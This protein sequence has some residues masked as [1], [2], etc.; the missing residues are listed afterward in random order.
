[1]TKGIELR[2]YQQA[3]VEAMIK[4]RRGMCVAPAGAGKTIIAAECVAAGIKKAYQDGNCFPSVIWIAH[5]TEQAEQGKAALERFKPDGFCTVKVCCYASNPDTRA[6]D[7]LI[8][9]EA[10][11]AGASSVQRLVDAVSDLCSVYGFTA[12]P[13]REDGVDIESIIGPIRYT[14][15]R[16]EIQ[17]VGGVLP[18]E[19]RVVPCGVKDALDD[20][21][22]ALAGNYYTSRL[23][24]CDD[25]N[26]T[27]EQWK[28]C[29]YRSALNI[30]IRENQA[31]DLLIQKICRLHDTDS[32]LI[33]VD[34]KEH[35]KR[36]K[37][38]IPESRFVSSGAAGR[39]KTIEAFKDGMI[40]VLI[41]TSLADEGLDAPIAG[42]LIMAGAGK[43]FGKI[44][45]RTGRVLRPHAGKDKGIIYDFHDL[46]HGMLNA[47][48]WQRRKTYKAAGYRVVGMGV[49]I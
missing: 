35:G 30:G 26:G 39:K 13:I 32:V 10:H 5:T 3:A 8:V 23:K 31:R 29:Q 7:I 44:I 42:V 40:N 14:V 25:K 2:P 6:A 49:A 21:V 20:E 48:H 33:L 24:W 43:A 17:A 4:H 46:G 22:A 37:E 38:R 11:H 18:A 34:S 41:C 12:T 28:R 16:D 47:Q 27:D 45:Q 1:M 19:V 15:G 36:I 9:D